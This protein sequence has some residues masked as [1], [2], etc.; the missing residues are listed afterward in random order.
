[1]NLRKV[2][3]LEITLVKDEICEL[4]ADS[5]NIFNTRNNSFCRLLNEHGLNDVRQTEIHTA[6]PLVPELSSLDF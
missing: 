3:N 1:M 6:E 2:T 5:N 4:L